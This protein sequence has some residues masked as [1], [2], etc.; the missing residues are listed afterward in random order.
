MINNDRLNPMVIKELRQGL[1]SRSFVASFLG[2]QG[3]M[4]LSMFIY[5]AAV[6]TGSG[7]L[8]F[9]DGFFWFMVGLLLIVIM[10]LRSFQALHDEI[11]NDTLELI[12]LTRMNAWKITFGKWCALVIQIFLLVSAILPYLVLRYFLGAINVT[13][14]LAQLFIQIVVS[15]L[16]V[17]IGVGLSAWTSKIMRGLLIVGALFSLYLIPLFLFGIGSSMGGAFFG[18]TG[19]IDV[20]VALIIAGIIMMFFI[21]YGASMIAPPAENHSVRKR[22]MAV[23]LTLVMGGYATYKQEAGILYM[24][25]GL[26]APM[27]IDALCEPLIGIPSV[28]QRLKKVRGLRWFL[29][30]G[31]ASGFLFVTVLFWSSILWAF[32]V[33]PDVDVWEVGV[34]SYNTLIFPFI[35]LRLIPVLSRKPLAGYFIIQVLSLAL[36]LLLVFL[37]EIHFVHKL[38]FFASALPV[39]GFLGILD[40]FYSGPEFV[41]SLFFGTVM[42]AIFWVV[43]LKPF[44]QMRY[45]CRGE[46]G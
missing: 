13:G 6:S 8:E 9:A 24:C 46:Q 20:V 45:L 11:K 23:L 17:S 25:I 19:W 37:E 14:N 2:L 30:P 5:L 27:G 38:D 26:L 22:S 35:L 34:I 43:S 18:W 40:S 29:F 33:E 21:Q 41:L 10:P 1:K 15:M 28:Y 32:F 36:S 4:V 16:L 44:K 42:L 12:F 7:D 39:L 3:L 31:W